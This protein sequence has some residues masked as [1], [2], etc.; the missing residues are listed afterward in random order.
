MRC[1]KMNPKARS[2]KVRTVPI[3]LRLPIFIFLIVVR[4]DF[5]LLSRTNSK[6]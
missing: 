3:T 5:D 6:F 4:M 1:F 2:K